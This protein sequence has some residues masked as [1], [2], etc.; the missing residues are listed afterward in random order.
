MVSQ[1]D[2]LLFNAVRIG[3]LDRVKTILTQGANVDVCDRYDTTALM[4]A[5]AQGYTE[6]VKLLLEA[7][8]SVNLY[9]R[10][11]RLTAL[12]L[13]AA[14]NQFDAVEALI[15]AGADVN[16]QNDDG[17]PALMIAAYKGH[18]KIVQVLLAA[19]ARINIQD[20]D[21]DTAL[22]LA[23]SSDLAEPRQQLDRLAIVATLLQVGANPDTGLG[24]LH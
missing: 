7:G 12:M 14:A 24:A 19:D 16:A 6:I 10:P 15:N 9:N 13:A 23:A 3:N 11:H 20:K 5:A 22:N 8:A 1:Q 18:L 21:G 4:Y 2:I 17:T